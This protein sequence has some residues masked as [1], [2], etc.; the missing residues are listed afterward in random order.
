MVEEEEGGRRAAHAD[1]HAHADAHGTAGGGVDEERVGREVG[2]VGYVYFY[3]AYYQVR[4][5]C[6]FCF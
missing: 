2:G 3:A 1:S 6:F 5:L 4:Y